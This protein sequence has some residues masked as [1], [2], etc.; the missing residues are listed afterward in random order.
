MFGCLLA[1]PWPAGGEE[2]G[3]GKLLIATEQLSGSVFDG[4][5]ILL[6]EH[7]P[8]GAVGV[9]LNKPLAA[10]LT[11]WLPELEELR[12]REDEI[13][14]GGP[15]A[16]TEL[17]LLIDAESPVSEATT[18]I[19]GVLWGRSLTTLL[20]LLADPAKPAFRAYAGYA[21]W[22]PG[23]LEGELER[24]AWIVAPA[25]PASIFPQEP[26]SLW[27]RLLERFRPVRVEAGPVCVE[28]TGVRVE[29]Q[30]RS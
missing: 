28:T 5:V 12:S 15:V 21:G 8:D 29:D 27:R 25:E 6:L 7:A 17:V 16:P 2:P 18:V 19:P 11:R 10:P 26:A 1:A 24:G 23:Q 14:L 13:W 20:A 3:Q 9:I 30:R 22:G 4:A